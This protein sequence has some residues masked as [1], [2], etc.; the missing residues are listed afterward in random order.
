MM[1]VRACTISALTS[2]VDC[3][4]VAAAR[5]RSAVVSSS[6]DT[7]S[8]AR[9]KV[10]REYVFYCTCSLLHRMRNYLLMTPRVK[11]LPCME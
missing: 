4:T 7:E 6:D 5:L 1:F 2:G 9:L 3:A 8:V 10:P 11:G